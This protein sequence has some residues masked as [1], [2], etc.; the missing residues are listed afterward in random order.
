MAVG[1]KYVRERLTMAKNHIYTAQ[2]RLA[3]A[4]AQF[5]EYGEYYGKYKDALTAVA[6]LLELAKDYIDK[7]LDVI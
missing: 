3:E 5:A 7:L 4:Y 2:D 1:R 6:E